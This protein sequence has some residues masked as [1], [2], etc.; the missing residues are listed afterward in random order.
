[1][2]SHHFLSYDYEVLTCVA[3][4]VQCETMRCYHVTASSLATSHVPHVIWTVL[5]HQAF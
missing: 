4:H 2:F 5:K 1:M 3:K